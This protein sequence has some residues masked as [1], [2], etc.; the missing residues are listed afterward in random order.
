MT[1][2][3][4]VGGTPAQWRDAVLDLAERYHRDGRREEAQ[5]AELDRAAVDPEFGQRPSAT[6]TRDRATACWARAEARQQAWSD[7]HA[8]ADR[9][10]PRPGAQERVR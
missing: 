4:E 9:L 8:L 5:A 2:P 1:G 10:D 7:L 3:R 6:S